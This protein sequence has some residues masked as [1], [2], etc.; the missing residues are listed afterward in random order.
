VNVLP[1]LTATCWLTG[2]AHGAMSTGTL[3]MPHAIWLL[4]SQMG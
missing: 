2:L 4:H 1:A 3:G